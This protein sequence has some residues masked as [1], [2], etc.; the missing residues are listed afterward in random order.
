MW[1]DTEEVQLARPWLPR[2][3]RAY[4]HDAMRVLYAAFALIGL[5]VSVAAQSASHDVHI[6]ATDITAISLD[7]ASVDIALDEVAVGGTTVTGSAESGMTLSTNIL[8]YKI[9]AQLDNDYSDSVTL[10]AYLDFTGVT[11]PVGLTISPLRQTLSATEPKDL[12][13]G[14]TPLSTNGIVIDYEATAPLSVGTD[15]DDTNTV[16]YTITSTVGL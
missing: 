11:L 4:L 14:L 2:G 7:D 13:I 12:V 3:P 6:Y 10:S 16:T 1:A 15:Y 5:S 9:S 8:L